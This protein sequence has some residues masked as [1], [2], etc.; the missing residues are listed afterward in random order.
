MDDS[1]A[2]DAGQDWRRTQEARKT[3][4]G[5]ERRGGRREGRRDGR[6]DMAAGAISAEGVTT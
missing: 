5:E 2:A 3:S 4:R 1:A 6:R